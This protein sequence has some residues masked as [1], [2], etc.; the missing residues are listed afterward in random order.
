MVN[1]HVLLERS[2]MNETLLMEV[3]V[4]G[5]MEKLILLIVLSVEV[6]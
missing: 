2:I 3:R 4:K 1:G 5:H 6:S